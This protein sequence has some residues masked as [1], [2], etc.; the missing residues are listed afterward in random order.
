M[1][2]AM[3]G[4]ALV[5]LL[6][7]AWGIYM[8][9]RPAA[10]DVP[11]Q[12]AAGRAVQAAPVDS[13]IPPGQRKRKE[14]RDPEAREALK[15]VGADPGAEMYWVQAINNPNLSKNERKDLIEDLN[16]EGYEN[17]K[18][19]TEADVQLIRNRIKLIEE[20]EPRAMDDVNAAAFKEVYKDL[21][22]ML[23]AAEGR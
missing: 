23:N 2:K 8:A 19:P 1:K 7:A 11:E 15:L 21:Q 17:R 16:D 22:K 5:L 12:E 13:F 9:V 14:N 10:E 6:F 3:M 20:L 18:K 4:L